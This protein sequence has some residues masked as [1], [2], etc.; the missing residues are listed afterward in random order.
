MKLVSPDG[1]AYQAGTLSG[2]PVAVA[3]GIATLRRLDP[4]L[5]RRIDA[6]AARIERAVPGVVRR[7]SMFTVFVKD[8]PRFFHGLLER[9]VYFPPSQFE[10]AFVGAAHT[11]RQIDRTIRAIH[12]ALRWERGSIPPTS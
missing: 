1:P 6:L 9:G 11:G 2:N 7:G 10:A 8:Y 3:A 4:S 12:D 5:Y